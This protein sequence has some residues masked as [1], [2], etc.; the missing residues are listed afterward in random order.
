MEARDL[1]ALLNPRSPAEQKAIL[2]AIADA[3][4]KLRRWKKLWNV[5]SCPLKMLPIELRSFG[6]NGQHC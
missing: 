1:I 4:A 6:M 2:L 5:D 3:D